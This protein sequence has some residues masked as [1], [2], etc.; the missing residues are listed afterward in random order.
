MCHLKNKNS[1][2]LLTEMKILVDFLGGWGMN[3]LVFRL[4]FDQ[5]HGNRH[6][7]FFLPGINNGGFNLVERVEYGDDLP[8]GDV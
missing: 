6:Q 3:S 1:F 8:F 5:L 7:V 2:F 4:W